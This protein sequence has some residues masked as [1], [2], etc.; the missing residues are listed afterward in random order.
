MMSVRPCC[1]CLPLTTITG[2]R[3][4]AAAKIK[5]VEASLLKQV[6]LLDC[7]GVTLALSA[8]QLV[9]PFRYPEASFLQTSTTTNM[10]RITVARV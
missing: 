2:D 6:I 3:S 5:Q 8:V 1:C 10:L 4:E 9:C 7:T